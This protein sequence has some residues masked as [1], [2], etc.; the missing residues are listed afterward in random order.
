MGRKPATKRKINDII[1]E[2]KKNP[3]LCEEDP[4]ILEYREIRKICSS[5]GKIASKIGEGKSA[6]ADAS[7]SAATAK[8]LAPT[9]PETPAASEV[10]GGAGA[11]AVEEKFLGMPKMVGYSVVGFGALV[12]L[13]IVGWL[14]F[15]GSGGGAAPAPA[16][17]K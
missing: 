5:Y 1:A 9:A 12:T 4:S 2:M 8:I 14:A 13:G 7:T 11:P 3:K 16:P 10:G 15:G 17:A 6:L